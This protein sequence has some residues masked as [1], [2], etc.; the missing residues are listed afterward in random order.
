MKLARN[1]IYI[2]KKGENPMKKNIE[3][4]KAALKAS[5]NKTIDEYYEEFSNRSKEPGFTIDDI[6]ELMLEQRRKI[7]ESLNGSNS[8]LASSIKT[9]GKKNALTA[10]DI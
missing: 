7:H 3:I 5:L 8:E 1:L 9:E 6:E 10:A 2:G 4:Q